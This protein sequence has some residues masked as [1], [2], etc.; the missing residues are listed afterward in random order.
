MKNTQSK[1][2]NIFRF[3]IPKNVRL[4]LWSLKPKIHLL[5]TYKLQREELILDLKNINDK[6]IIREITWAD[7]AKI[8]KAYQFRG[9]KAFRNLIP[10]R[11]NSGNWIGLAVIDNITGDIAYLAW[12][13]VKSIRYFEEFGIY[14]KPGQ[15]LLKDGFCVPEYRH[16]GL[17]T[18][19][20]QERINYCIKNGAKDIFIQ[21]Q[22]ENEK[23]KDSVRNNGYVLINKKYVIA[24][25]VF[26]TY[27]VFR[28]FLRNPFMKVI[29]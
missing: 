8:R 13:I 29:S 19:M 21:I 12:I 25:P 9:R 5:N 17:H 24:W 20:E 28:S 14:L 15:F 18:R 16:Q 3:I 27:R 6:Y 23:G 26:N 22:D 11:M 10:A 4:F 2:K 1:V 7:E